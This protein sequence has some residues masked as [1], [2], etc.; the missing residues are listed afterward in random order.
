[1]SHD[2]NFHRMVS[3]TGLVRLRASSLPQLSISFFAFWGSPYPEGV[4]V[5]STGRQMR[6]RYQD[7]I[8]QF[9]EYRQP[10]RLKFTLI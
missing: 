8:Y 3:T 1:M 7:T 4:P 5:N 6:L 9:L 2:Q 10:R